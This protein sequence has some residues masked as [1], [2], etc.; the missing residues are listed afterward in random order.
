MWKAW[1]YIQLCSQH[2]SS[3][4][5]HKYYHEGR[6]K[7]MSFKFSTKLANWLIKWCRRFLSA[8]SDLTSKNLHQRRLLHHQLQSI[9]VTALPHRQFQKRFK[10]SPEFMQSP[11]E[12]FILFW[13]E[14]DVFFQV[15]AIDFYRFSILIRFLGVWIHSYN[16]VRS[17]V[18]GWLQF[19][20]LWS[21]EIILRF[22]T[23]L[24]ND[25]IKRNSCVL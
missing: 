11:P 2:K 12:E 8:H 15:S 24:S 16:I 3:K 22:Y 17:H 23:F 25:P 19:V 14:R 5:Q 20:V 18:E 4:V 7:Q 10:V 6:H 21:T 1:Y 9:V 13:R